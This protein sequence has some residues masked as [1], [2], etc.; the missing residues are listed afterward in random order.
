MLITIVEFE[1]P[2]TVLTGRLG[3]SYG[4]CSVRVSNRFD[5]TR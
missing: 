4:V 2:D 1:R 3:R 5:R